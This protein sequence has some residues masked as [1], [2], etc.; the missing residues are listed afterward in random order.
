MK[1]ET[2]VKYNYKDN[3]IKFTRILIPLVMGLAVTIWLLLHEFNISTFTSFRHFSDY[4]YFILLAILLM[5]LKDFAM[6]WRFRILTNND[7]SWRQA[8]HINV[9]SEFTTAVTPVAIG[10]SSLVAIFLN[11][12]GVSIGRSTSIMFINL[13]LDELFFILVCPVFLYFTPIDEL[14]NHSTVLVSS[15]E[16]IFKTAFILR[17]LWILFLY[18]GIFKKTKWIIKLID[19][20]FR[21][22][23]IRRWKSKANVFS[24]S[25]HQAS[26]EI[27][28]YS[29]LFWFKIMVITF[30]AWTVRFLVVNVIILAFVP[31]D[32][33]MLVFA[34]QLIMWFVMIASP[35]P[36]GSGVSEL[37]FKDYFSDIILS[38]SAAI[39]AMLVWRIITYYAYIVQGAIVIPKWIKKSLKK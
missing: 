25:L 21:V 19:L 24:D 27:A 37:A 39:S 14:F 33:H 7:L 10:G 36:G 15:F 9:L 11:K 29:P 28:S 20:M 18:I 34:R 22:P 1:S 31:V 12:E 38:D 30:F 8:F 2:S 13:I 23:V 3:P 6:I 17:F 32:N 35:T 5:A 26:C 16:L 4:S